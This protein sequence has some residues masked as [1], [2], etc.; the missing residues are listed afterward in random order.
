MFQIHFSMRILLLSATE[1]EIST[2]VRHLE[3]NA[4]TSSLTD[5]KTKNHEVRILVSGVGPVHMAFALGRWFDSK[6]FDL[7]LHAGI[8][9]SFNDNFP[10][11]SMLEVVR[12]RF[13]DL[14]A[15]N[16]EG[17]TLD[18]FD[19]GF[20]DQNR[21]PYS[22]GW[23]EK[24]KIGME[25]NLPKAS[26]IT[27]MR[28][29]G[30]L[31]TTERLKSQYQADIESMEG[32]SVFYACRMLDIPFVSIR[33]VSNMVEKRDKSKWNIVGAIENLNKTLIKIFDQD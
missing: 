13:A 9:G 3:S 19:L 30:T 4:L 12:E 28:S 25:L 24:K 1:E 18:I 6:Q 33:C 16:E 14:G 21:F 27:V 5:F 26:G 10:I 29:T 22:D 11:N 7:V 15:E 23:C 32:A 20:D 31:S 17:L 8:C 2:T